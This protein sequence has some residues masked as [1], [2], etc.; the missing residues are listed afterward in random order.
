MSE[1]LDMNIEEVHSLYQ[2]LLKIHE[3]L[4]DILSRE[5]DILRA[6]LN[7]NE[8]VQTKKEPA[9]EDEYYTCNGCGRYEHECICDLFD[10]E[11]EESREMSI[12][13]YEDFYD[14]E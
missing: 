13:E 2:Q 5:N 4:L 3:R 9:T 7:N 11:Q 10:T 14:E 8:Q 12:M 1:S 6:R